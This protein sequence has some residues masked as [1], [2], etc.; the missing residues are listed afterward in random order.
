MDL[1]LDLTL[2]LTLDLTL[3]PILDLLTL[4]L[5]L[6]HVNYIYTLHM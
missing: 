4:D 6:P 3:D 1:T 2:H 5:D